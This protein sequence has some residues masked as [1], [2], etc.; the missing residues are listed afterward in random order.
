[1][2]KSS[3]PDDYITRIVGFENKRTYIV[4]FSVSSVSLDIYSLLKNQNPA[5]S[6]IGFET[7]YEG[8]MLS[9]TNPKVKSHK[10]YFGVKDWQYTDDPV[11]SYLRN[12]YKDYKDN[13]IDRI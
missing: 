6:V 5:S 10:V 12:L 3:T 7:V 4:Y 13:E 1:M 2:G 11:E 8:E 9:I